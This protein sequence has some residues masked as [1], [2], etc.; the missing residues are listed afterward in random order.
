MEFADHRAAVR[1]VEGL[2]QDFARPA[3]QRTVEQ[4]SQA[5]Q[6]PALPPQS[7]PAFR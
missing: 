3:A 5:A 6:T 1:G 2:A 7:V 4:L